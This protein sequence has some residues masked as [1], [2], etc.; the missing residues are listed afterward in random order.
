[1]VVLAA[2][3]IHEGPSKGDAIKAAPTKMIMMTTVVQNDDTVKTTVVQ[4]D[5]TV[6]TTVVQDDRS[7]ASS[8]VNLAHPNYSLKRWL[9]AHQQ[10]W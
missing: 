10:P 9:A 6:K 3:Y 5:D 7:A 2:T 4:N 8:G 1:M